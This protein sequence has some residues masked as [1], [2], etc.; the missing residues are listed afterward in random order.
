MSF[1]RLPCP[2]RAAAHLR[3]S[4][5]P[6]RN[7][8]AGLH[9]GDSRGLGNVWHVRAGTSGEGPALR[10]SSTPAAP[11]PLPTPG[12]DVRPLP[13]PLGCVTL[14]PSPPLSGECLQGGPRILLSFSQFRS[15]LETPEFL[16]LAIALEVDG[17]TAGGW[18]LIM[19]ILPVWG[20]WT[21]ARRDGGK[22]FFQVRGE[23]LHT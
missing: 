21:L 3:L 2:S 9:C 15:A 5:P 19:G 13:S 16:S 4:R 7:E 18:V 12:K 23:G 11:P 17:R 14:P 8:G 1:P 6:A 10:P 22:T 20:L